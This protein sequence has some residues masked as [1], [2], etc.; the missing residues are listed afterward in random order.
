MTSGASATNSAAYCACVGIARAPA[1]VDLH[2]SAVGPAQFLQLLHE[3]RDAGF[4]FRIV[5]GRYENADAPHSLGRC[6]CAASGQPPPAADSVMNSRHGLV[7]APS[8]VEA[9]FLD[10]NDSTSG[11]RGLGDNSRS[12]THL[13]AFMA[14]FLTVSAF[15]GCSSTRGGR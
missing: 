2:V 11:P 12:V 1:I 8:A 13:V 10:S 3:R 6:A 7:L 5:R 15:L 9:D 14:A 4:R